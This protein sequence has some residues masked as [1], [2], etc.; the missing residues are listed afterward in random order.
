MKEK[1]YITIQFR[2]HGVNA[3][4]TTDIDSRVNLEEA[5]DIAVKEFITEMD[6]KGIKLDDDYKDTRWAIMFYHVDTVK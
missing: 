4:R 2:V 6:D 3:N 1:T 5:Y